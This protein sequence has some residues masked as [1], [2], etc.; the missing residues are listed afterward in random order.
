MVT[1]FKIAVLN[2]ED[3]TARIY[4]NIQPRLPNFDSFKEALLSSIPAFKNEPLYM[5]YEGK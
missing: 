1:F 3:E 2:H 4:V 5:Y